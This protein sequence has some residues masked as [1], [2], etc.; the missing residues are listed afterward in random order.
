MTARPQ[1]AANRTPPGQEGTRLL[2]WIPRHAPSSSSAASAVT[3]HFLSLSLQNSNSS[4]SSR[5]FFLQ[6]QRCFRFSLFSR[7]LQPPHCSLAYP[8]PIT[9]GQFLSYLINLAFTKA[10]GT[11]RWMLGWQESLLRCNSC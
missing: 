9:T 8:L 11:W 6:E 10:P 4:S 5:F 1:A 2:H 3:S 7:R